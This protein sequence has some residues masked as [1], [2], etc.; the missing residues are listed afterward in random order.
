M[1]LAGLNHLAEVDWAE[2]AAM[3]RPLLRLPSGSDLQ[4]V[5]CLLRIHLLRPVSTSILH[6][7]TISVDRK[8]F[9]APN[10]FEHT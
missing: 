9:I 8:N 1:P 5:R 4:S 7:T 3:C 10:D 6:V 2:G